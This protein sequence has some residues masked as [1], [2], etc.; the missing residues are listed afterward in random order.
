MKYKLILVLAILGFSKGFSQPP[1]SPIL[2]F[3]PTTISS[4]NILP[5]EVS[6]FQKVNFLPVSNYTGRVNIDIPFYEI[7]LN[8][9]KIPIGLSYN[10]GGVKLNEVASSVG[11]NWSLNAGGAISKIV[12]GIEDF[13]IPDSYYDYE[14]HQYTYTGPVGWL[15]N[16]L[17]VPNPAQLNV[18]GDPLPD[19]FIVSAPNINCTF[20]HEPLFNTNGVNNNAG[21]PFVLDGDESFLIQETYGKVISGMWGKYY[22]SVGYGEQSKYFGGISFDPNYAVRGI[23]KITI[24]SIDGYEY[25]FDKPDVSQ[26]LYN[27][28][29]TNSFLPV[30]QSLWANV[31]IVAY[32]LTKIKDLKTMKTVDFEYETY[33][34]AFSEIIDN[35]RAGAE[36][37]SNKQGVWNRYPKLNRIKKI[38]FD[39]GAIIFNYNLDREDITGEKAL[40]SITLYNLR[41]ERIKQANLNFDYFMAYQFDYSPYSKRLKLNDVTIEGIDNSSNQKYKLTYNETQLPTRSVTVSDFLGYYN[42]ESKNFNYYIDLTEDNFF[43]IKYPMGKPIAT[44][45]FHQNNKQNSFLPLA[46]NANA[47][48]VLGNY[49]L[50]PN[51]NFC[52]A[53]IL[54][55]I[56]YPTGGY[57]ELDYE[58]NRFLLNDVEIQGGGLRVRQQNIS[59]G[60]TVRTLKYEYKTEENKSSG[61]VVSIPRFI[62]FQYKGPKILFPENFTPV[63]FNAWF[64]VEK[65][66]LSKSNVELTNGVYVGYSRV[67]VFEENKGYT[68]YSYTSPAQY[69]NSL[70]VESIYY[71]PTFPNSIIWDIYIKNGK[72]EL[73]F[74]NDIFRGKIVNT[75][76]FTQN[77]ILLKETLYNYT[78]K[79]YDSIPISYKTNFILDDNCYLEFNSNNCFSYEIGKFKKRRFLMTG[80]T[81]KEYFNGSMMSRNK[82][83]EYDDNYGLIR[84]ELINDDTDNFRNEYYYPFDNIVQNEFGMSNLVQNN[85]KAERILTYSFKNGEK[86]LEQKML[87]GAYYVGV[88]PKQEKKYKLMTSQDG[89]NTMNSLEVTKRDEYG[90]IW[91]TVDE[92]GVKCAYIWGYNKTELLAKIQNIGTASISV[93]ILVELEET[94]AYGPESNLLTA[95]NSLR[96]SLPNAMITT[97]TYKPL[98]GVST[99]TDEK[100]NRITYEYD[101]LGRLKAVRD[102]NGNILSENEYHYKS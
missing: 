73:I 55:R 61:S 21:K 57:I 10:T 93:D 86:L 46:L 74:N 76:I 7:D 48:P 34:L 64:D 24:K 53:A 12:K 94:S 9:F 41:G 80:V 38:T 54:E 26:Y 29:V 33:S 56:E 45:Y 95:L 47:I 84:K 22:S 50:M 79:V 60:N 72:A 3:S 99:I 8:G 63:Q 32:R 51:L 49:S 25:T 52:K 20:I 58:L 2:N 77:N 89:T 59:D 78:A 101:T 81:E 39:K 5:P 30:N 66:N 14:M 92:F 11:L 17:P 18:S 85:R 69:P 28:D 31:N 44:S 65:F 82:N 27:R 87:Y 67:K 1:T 35:H 6:S 83:I 16:K 62:D 97:Y 98:V 70:P 40:T 36:L 43:S 23:D 68:L 102:K 4:P 100:G 75:K 15:F 96:V 71:D 42:G 88:L 37:S 19:E 90:N 91:E 13:E